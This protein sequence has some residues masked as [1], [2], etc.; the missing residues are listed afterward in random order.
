MTDHAL[1]SS[2]EDDAHASEHHHPSPEFHRLLDRLER[3]SGVIFILVVLLNF[4]SATG[5]YVAGT[6]IMG[7][8]EVQVFT[9]IWLIFLGAAMAALRR[10]HLRM[11]VL[12]M[13][14]S[15]R[16]AWWRHLAEA[17]LTM[18]VC[19][20]MV[21]VSS[22]FTYQIYGMEQKSDAAEIPMWIPHISV[23]VGFTGMLLCSLIELK[24]LLQ[25]RVRNHFTS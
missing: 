18:N 23:V 9:M 13:N 6:P 2:T 25:Q 5:R 10:M 19:A 1:K 15:P 21:W 7:A 22:D 24:A 16:W 17:L 4:A 11:D 3:F 12:T 20:V 8:D 14:L